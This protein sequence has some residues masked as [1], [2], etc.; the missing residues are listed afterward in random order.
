MHSL[1]RKV[2]PGSPMELLLAQEDKK[3]MFKEKS[4]AK[5][6]KGNGKF[7]TRLHT[8]KLPTCAKE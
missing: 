4:D 7:K 1:R 8:A 3:K 6:N 5:W 2:V